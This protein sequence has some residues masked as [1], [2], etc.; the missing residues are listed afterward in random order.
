MVTVGLS[1]GSSV[2][3]VVDLRCDCLVCFCA[4]VG[5]SSVTCLYLCVVGVTKAV[6]VVG[7]VGVE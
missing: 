7:G 5:S 6:V 1:N 4:G 3:G 2:D